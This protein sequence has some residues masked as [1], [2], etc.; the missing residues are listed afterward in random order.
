MSAPVSLDSTI[1]AE[2]LLSTKLEDEFVLL[3]TA[4]N[5]YY[6][7][8]ETGARVWELIQEPR[9]VRE[10]H[11]LMLAELDVDAEEWERDLLALLQSLVDEELAK[12]EE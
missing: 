2:R 9:S 11:E 1:V 7:L 5:L 8:N 3:S 12:T 6:G 10:I 4:K